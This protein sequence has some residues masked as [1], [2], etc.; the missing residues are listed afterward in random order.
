MTHPILSNSGQRCICP[1]FWQHG[2]SEELLRE[3]IQQMKASGI[4][5]FIAEARPHPDYLGEGW[6]RDLA[7]LLDEAQKQSMT[8]WI[9]D[10]G[11]YPSGNANGRIRQEYPECL[12]TYWREYHIDATG[13]RYGSSFLVEDFLQEGETLYRVLAAP[14]DRPPRRAAR[15]HPAGSHRPGCRRPALL[16]SARRRMADLHTGS[17]PSRTGG[18]HQR[19]CQ[20]H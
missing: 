8:V 20:P 14:E 1:L 2:E 11:D 12:K 10:D 7:I 18:A 13:P 15:R 17:L 5:S 19:P 4:D 9:F 3:E 6:W 16:G